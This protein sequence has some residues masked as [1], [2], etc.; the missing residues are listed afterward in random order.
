[1]SERRSLVGGPL[2]PTGLVVL[3]LLLWLGFL[4]HHS[5]RFAGSLWG[6]L[7][8]M[9]GA[10][11]MLMPMAYTFVK[12][13]PRLK[14]WVTPRISMRTL[15]AWHI[16]TG[17]LGAI[18]GLLHTGHKFD[19]PLGIALTAMMLL[20]VLS[21]FAGRYLLGQISQE[22]REK[23]AMLA[24]L[25]LAY[26]R[27]A[28]EVAAHPEQLA[29]LRPLAGFWGRLFGSLYF[30]ALATVSGTATAS[31]PVRI[32]RLAESIADVEYA[33]KSH[34]T[35]KRWFT[36]WLWFHIVTSVA[37]YALLALHVWTGIYFGL[38]WLR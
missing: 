34:E 21:G 6:G 26:R 19:S 2:A 12:R 5:H 28:G 3:M 33:I 35:L 15:L 17:L 9:S 1:M 8:G 20:V 38:R 27:T 32:L 4:V 30:T 13:I 11:L 14:R 18:L 36:G 10:L 22:L 25:E 7:L 31:A 37:M 23:K 24:Q 29:A 16:Y